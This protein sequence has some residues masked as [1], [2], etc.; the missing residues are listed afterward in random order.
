MKYWNQDAMIQP[1]ALAGQK[2]MWFGWGCCLLIQRLAVTL[3]INLQSTRH[4]HA[5]RTVTVRISK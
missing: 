4:T 5:G 1:L 3:V 2:A